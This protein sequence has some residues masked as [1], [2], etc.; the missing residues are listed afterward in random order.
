MA[1]ASVSFNGITRR[2]F[3]AGC[4]ATAAVAAGATGESTEAQLRQPTIPGAVAESRVPRFK[5]PEGSCD[6]HA[7]VFGPQSRF[8]YIPNAAYIPPDQTVDDY[9]RTLKRLG[10]SRAVLVQPSVYGTDHAAMIEAM[11]SGKFPFRGV[12]VVSPDV[13]DREL[14]MLHAAGFRGIRIN[15]L[16]KNAGLPLDAA[17]KLGR[18]IKRLG[19]HLQFFLSVEKL[20]DVEQ[21]LGG[22]PV[23]VVIDHFGSIDGSAG[24][25]GAGFERLLR[26]MARDNV[27]VKLS[28]PY[29]VTKTPAGIAEVAP[30][31]HRM[32]EVAP[33]RLV[34]GTDWPHP[35]AAWIPDDGDL[36]DLL[37]TWLP[38]ERLRRRVLVENPAR[39]YDFK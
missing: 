32:L 29:H 25:K 26:L 27:W 28:G 12:A 3:V 9:I 15:G 18:Q 30:F 16:S 34:W 37:P 13:T 1:E 31:V 7:H 11:G 10:V 5:L 19:W 39:L 2:A 6:C 4:A 22:L 33:D 14:D 17:P 8:G 38:D 20:A 36:V 24:L 35:T 21:R 23:N